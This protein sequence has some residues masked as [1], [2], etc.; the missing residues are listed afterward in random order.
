M[1][2]ANEKR[3]EC[4]IHRNTSHLTRVVPMIYQ[5]LSKHEPVFGNLDN[6]S[7]IPVFQV[8]AALETGGNNQIILNL[9]P[10]WDKI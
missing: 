2:S 10:N 1:I 8:W 4:F 6:F 9:A 5:I 7:L 3:E